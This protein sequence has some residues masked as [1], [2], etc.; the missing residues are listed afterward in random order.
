M[1]PQNL[2]MQDK[3]DSRSGT[4]GLLPRL[5]SSSTPNQEPRPLVAGATAHITGPR[6][7]TAADIL[8]EEGLHLC[9]PCTDS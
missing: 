7:K 4:Q 1:S 2:R 3:V 5:R 9:V 8:V 6:A